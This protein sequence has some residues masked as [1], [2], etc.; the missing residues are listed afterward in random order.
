MKTNPPP[1][2]TLPPLKAGASKRP[3]ILSY[4]PDL[5]TKETI[6]QM[7]NMAIFA[8]A[9]IG[10]STEELPK[11]HHFAVCAAGQVA[12]ICE[13]SLELFEFASGATVA[14]LCATSA[15]AL[16]DEERRLIRFAR[17]TL[18]RLEAD[19]AWSADTTNAAHIVRCV[20]SHDAL[21]TALKG[22][23]AQIKEHNSRQQTLGNC[24]VFPLDVDA[25]LAQAKE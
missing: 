16:S 25:A 18:A 3:E 6:L 11:T 14:H 10:M 1:A 22:L 20:N 17:E 21:L 24:I 4:G 15:A 7:R 5:S 2:A 12:H 8:L 19:K 9:H 23:V 13:S